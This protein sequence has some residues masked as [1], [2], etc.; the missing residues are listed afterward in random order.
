MCLEGNQRGRHS[1]CLASA[2]SAQNRLHNTSLRGAPLFS[3]TFH[4]Y[5]RVP[6]ALVTFSRGKGQQLLCQGEV[7]IELDKQ[8]WPVLSEVLPSDT[9]SPAVPDIVP[10]PSAQHLPRSSLSPNPREHL[11]L[12]SSSQ[13]TNLGLLMTCFSSLQKISSQTSV[14]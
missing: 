7:R 3:K 9:S 4:H 2:T 13:A 8:A 1:V 11:S 10:A 5:F 14:W 12:P 6:S